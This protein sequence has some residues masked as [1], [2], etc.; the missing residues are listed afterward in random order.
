[1]L[2]TLN[3]CLIQKNNLFRAESNRNLEIISCSNEKQN[4]A[5]PEHTS[6]VHRK[7]NKPNNKWSLFETKQNNYK[8]G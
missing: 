2:G 8:S 1:M 3:I 5:N 6:G 7:A 4:P